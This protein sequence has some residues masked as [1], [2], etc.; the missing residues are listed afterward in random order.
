MGSV[1]AGRSEI[2]RVPT[3]LRVYRLREELTAVGEVFGDIDEFG[4]GVPAGAHKQGESLIGDAVS[5]PALWQPVF[6]P[7]HRR[8]RHRH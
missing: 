1:T 6:D 2:N 8:S 4:I 3:L 5:I 7:P